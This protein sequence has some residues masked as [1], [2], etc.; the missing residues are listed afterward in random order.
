MDDV[1]PLL[2]MGGRGVPT[3]A[4]CD[5][6]LLCQECCARTWRAFVRSLVFPG[7]GGW[8]ISVFG[9]ELGVGVVGGTRPDIPLA[10]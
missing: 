7:I 6:I 1:A 10:F 5:K 4:R 3:F 8:S 2:V 9:I